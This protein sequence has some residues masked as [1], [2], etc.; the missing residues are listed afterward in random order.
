M[1]GWRCRAQHCAERREV[2]RVAGEDV[3]AEAYGGDHHVGVDDV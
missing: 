2:A 3:V 1:D